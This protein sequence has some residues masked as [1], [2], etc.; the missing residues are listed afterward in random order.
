MPVH[1][2]CYFFI[3]YLSL[4]IQWNILI[5][6]ELTSRIRIQLFDQQTFMRPF[7]KGHHEMPSLIVNNVEIVL[8]AGI[9]L[10]ESLKCY[11]KGYLMVDNTCL[12]YVDPN[13]VLQEGV[14]YALIYL[15]GKKC[16][17]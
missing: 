1:Y 8:E 17:Y 7:C 4:K 15:H 11:P 6:A 9:T 3:S 5:L 2:K 14:K 16:A 13:F 10:K 12:V